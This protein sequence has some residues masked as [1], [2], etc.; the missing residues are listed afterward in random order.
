V[1][2]EGHGFCNTVLSYDEFSAGP[3]ATRGGAAPFCV[4]LDRF[5]ASYDPDG[6]AAN[7]RADIRYAGLAGTG[8]Q[9]AEQ[10]YRLQVNSPL[11][12]QG[13]RVYLISHGFAPRFTVRTPGGQEFRDVSAPFLPQD[14]NLTSE[15][16]IKLP[17]ALPQQLGIEGLFAPTAVET[18]DGVISSGSPQPSSP[19]VAIF[20]YRGQLGLDTGQAQ[21]VYNIDQRQVA[22]GALRRVAAANLRP[23]GTVKLADGT[24]VTFDGYRQWA[25]LQVARDPGQRLVLVAFGFL[26]LGLLLS[27]SVRRRR[28]WV[29]V[30]TPSGPGETGQRTVVEVGGL[31]RTEAGGFG[32]EFARL[33][34]RLCGSR[35]D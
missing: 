11:R 26:L 24:T 17:D 2:E 30:T 27:L 29:R 32:S 35:E 4:D 31:A 12:V 34:Q 14:G 15:G 5:T 33:V 7:F 25:S 9:P 20:V 8:G 13:V 10:P 6:T 1:L 3:L 21:S 23:G 22:S 18:A 19:E 28:C 16:A